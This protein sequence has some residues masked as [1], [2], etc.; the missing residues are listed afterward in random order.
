MRFDCFLQE[1]DFAK[2]REQ[3]KQMIVSGRVFLCGK[4]ITKPAFE[5][6]S[7]TEMQ[8]I[9]IRPDPADR[10]VSRGGCKLEAALSAFQV[11]PDGFVCLDIGASTGGFT[12]CLLQHGAEKVYAVENGH[13]QLD[14]GL[15][16]DE[17]CV[18]ME[19]TDARCLSPDDFPGVH[20]DLAVMD[21]SFISQTLMYP[22]LRSLLPQ[23]AGMITLIKPQF[24]A[25]KGQVGKR[26]V[27]KSERVRNE[28][29]K[30]VLDEACRFGFTPQGLIP[31]P[32]TGKNGNMEFLA[33]F[34]RSV[35]E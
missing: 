21:V 34:I 15:A 13:G 2:S 30:R 10:F 8:S 31:S 11:D 5:I 20:F 1:H 32:I 3:A 9:Q 18:M 24:E 12:D 28:S 35:K 7:G 19:Q 14:P 4:C 17:R 26:G 27:V 16:R 22:A 23:G 6:P 29:A 33:Y 25:G